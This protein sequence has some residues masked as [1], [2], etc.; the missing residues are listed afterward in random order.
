VS[1]LTKIDTLPARFTREPSAAAQR[2][3][4]CVYIMDSISDPEY[5]GMAMG[6]GWM[7]GWR[8]MYVAEFGRYGGGR[9]R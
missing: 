1:L 4:L 5:G 6:R 8:T 2:A 3:Q 7:R 9:D